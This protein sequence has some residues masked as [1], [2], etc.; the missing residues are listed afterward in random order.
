MVEKPVPERAYL[1]EATR[2][3]MKLSVR[4]HGTQFA[5]KKPGSFPV[6]EGF[7]FMQPFKGSTFSSFENTCNYLSQPSQ[8]E[9][10]PKP[11][12]TTKHNQQNKTPEEVVKH[13]NHPQQQLNKKKNNQ[14]T[15]TS[16]NYFL[17]ST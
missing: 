10:N 11:T 3:T 4:L 12:P 7:E 16:N 9:H 14:R 13:K 15:N 5:R 17:T 2:P 8:P 6:F 1:R